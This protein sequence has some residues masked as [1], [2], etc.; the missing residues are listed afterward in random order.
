MGKQPR[1]NEPG[2][3]DEANKTIAEYKREHGIPP[4]KPM[5]YTLG[6]DTYE[7]HDQDLVGDVPDGATIESLSVN[8]PVFG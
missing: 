3:Q 2:E 5:V 4:E 8:D 6:T 1:T 7:L